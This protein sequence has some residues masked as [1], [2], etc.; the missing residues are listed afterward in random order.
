MILILQRDPHSHGDAMTHDVLM[1]YSSKDKLQA[2]A[3]C[4]R[5]ESQGIR[6]WIAPRDVPLGTEY[7]DSIV[8]AIES[9]SVMVLVFSS[10]ADKSHQVRREVERAVSKGL[11]IVPVRIEESEMSKSFELY[12][13]SMHWLDA[14][15]PPLE[16][17][18]DK[19]AADLNALLS[20]GDERSTTA[21]PGYAATRETAVEPQRPAVQAPTAGKAKTSHTVRNAL[22]GAAAAVLILGGAAAWLGFFD[23]EERPISALT[24]FKTIDESA[25]RV[26]IGDVWFAGSKQLL[27]YS[28]V[29]PDESTL[30][31][32]DLKKDKGRVIHQAMAIAQSTMLSATG[33]FR[34]DGSLI[35]CD[36]ENVT[37]YDTEFLAQQTMPCLELATS[38]MASHQPMRTL[39]LKDRTGDIVIYTLGKSGYADPVRFKIEERG[40]DLTISKSEQWVAVSGGYESEKTT[41]IDVRK[42]RV[43]DLV[44]PGSTG[45]YSPVFFADDRYVAVGGGYDDGRISVFRTSDWSLEKTIPAFEHYCNS[46]ASSPDGQYLVAG[47]YN[48]IVKVYDTSSWLVVAEH[49]IGLH[50]NTVQFANTMDYVVVGTGAG[51][52]NTQKVVLLKISR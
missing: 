26:D 20:K 25:Y 13:S 45:A 4:N 21:A 8:Q 32:Y 49:N 3:I 23:S 27:A 17:H 16:E 6:C 46:L 19:L 34:G 1:S 37:I 44:A 12:L 31:V 39:A 51:N 52:E 50:V 43:A 11:T 41:I 5:L 2:D 22:I 28:T 40:G 47:G 10:H 24:P 42:G 36:G 7:A 14:I 30:K 15:T 48:G 18:I 38:R 9:V 35:D 29:S 33:A